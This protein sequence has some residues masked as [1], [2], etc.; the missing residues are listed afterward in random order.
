MDPFLLYKRNSKGPF[1]DPPARVH[2][3]IVF[4]PGVFL[5]EDFIKQY[6][7]THII[8]CAFDESVPSNIQEDFEDANKYAVLNALDTHEVNITFWFPLFREYM[9]SFL[10]DPSCK[11]VYVNCQAGMNRSGFLTLLY[12][13][14][15]FGYDYAT[16][17]RAILVQRPCALENSTFD[18][19]VQDYI[20]KH[21]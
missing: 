8:N 21:R 4:G 20:K 2:P 3:R 13:C 12:I 6:S 11:T 19:Q 14:I 9:D 5:T 16:A 17:K 1:A 15:K 18:K 7:I 10:R